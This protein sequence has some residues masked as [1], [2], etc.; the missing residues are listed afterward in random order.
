MTL[1][2]TMCTNY[3]RNEPAALGPGRR[4]PRGRVAGGGARGRGRSGGD[5]DSPPGNCNHVNQGYVVVSLTG[6]VAARPAHA[7]ADRTPTNAKCPRPV[8]LWRFEG[9]TGRGAPL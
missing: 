4:G 6:H 8:A 2:Y 1:L 7:V 5:S 3:S 9:V